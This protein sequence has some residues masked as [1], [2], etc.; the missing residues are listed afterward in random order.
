MIMVRL[1]ALDAALHPSWWDRD[2]LDYLY[3]EA[4][5]WLQNHGLMEAKQ[6]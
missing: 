5:E 4:D 1:M 6:E 3:D 2:Y